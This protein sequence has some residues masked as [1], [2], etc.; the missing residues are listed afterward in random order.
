LAGGLQC[1]AEFGITNFEAETT[2]KSQDGIGVLV[3]EIVCFSPDEESAKA[4]LPGDS[5]EMGSGVAK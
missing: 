1:V 3:K 2:L 5:T 4:I